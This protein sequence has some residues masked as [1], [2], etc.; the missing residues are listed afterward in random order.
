MHFYIINL[1]VTI[2]GLSLKEVETPIVPTF[3]VLIFGFFF[4]SILLSS[5]DIASKTVLQCYLIDCEMFVGEQRYVE[6][7]IKAFMEYYR[8]T[9]EEDERTIFKNQDYIKGMK[10]ARNE[11]QV[12][13]YI[14]EDLDEEENKKFDREVAKSSDEEN[15]DE[16]ED[17]DSDEESEEDNDSNN[18]INPFSTKIVIERPN[19]VEDQQLFPAMPMQV[20]SPAQN[21]KD[22]DEEE[23]EEEDEEPDPRRNIRL[24][25]AGSA[26]D[27]VHSGNTP[28]S[29]SKLIE[30]NSEGGKGFKGD[31][32]S[33]FNKSKLRDSTMKL[34]Y[35]DDGENEMKYRL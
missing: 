29:K 33:L 12:P 24:N 27:S 23:E 2:T 9:L 20:S 6:A 17:N 11:V 7:K 13:T 34:D 5:A 10:H 16:D 14:E 32:P 4:S 30:K 3:L 18:N 21:N 31:A 19:G 35:D 26:H 22:S 8:K 28:S 1:P 25:S 15:S